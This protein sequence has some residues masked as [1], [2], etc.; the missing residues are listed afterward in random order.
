[1]PPLVCV[2]CGRVDTDNERGWRSFL[3]VDE[4][5]PVEAIILCPSCAE[6]EFGSARR[7]DAG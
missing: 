7:T 1:V 2:E 5:D 4:E 6:R 3:T